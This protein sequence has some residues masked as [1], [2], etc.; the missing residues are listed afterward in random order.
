MQILSQES[1]YLLRRVLLHLG[2][3]VSIGIQSEAR[4]VVS[5]HAGQGFHIHPIFIYS[6]QIHMLASPM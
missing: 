1:A 6:L 2:G 4:G 5:Q 3:D